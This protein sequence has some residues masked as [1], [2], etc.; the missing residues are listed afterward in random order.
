MF[1]FPTVTKC[2]D[3]RR[4]EKEVS[5]AGPL[6]LS[7]LVLSSCLQIHHQP[8]HCVGWYKLQQTSR[9]ERSKV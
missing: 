2:F 7:L 8:K 5:W 3:H 4:L 6:S 1:G 9:M